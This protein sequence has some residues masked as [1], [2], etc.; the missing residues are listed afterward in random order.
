[1]NA[2]TTSSHG[3]TPFEV[4]FGTRFQA[5]FDEEFGNLV[6]EHGNPEAYVQEL[7]RVLGRTHSEIHTRFQTYH[8]KMREGY[9]RT[10]AHAPA[11]AKFRVG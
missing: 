11:R 1:M 5:P 6:F 10:R 3:Y 8:Q 7:R 2:T 9:Q 4:M